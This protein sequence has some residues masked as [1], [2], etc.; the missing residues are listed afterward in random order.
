MQGMLSAITD[1]S[2]PPSMNC[3]TL[4]QFSKQFRKAQ[5]YEW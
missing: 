2:N 4:Y 3:G 1:S 5:H